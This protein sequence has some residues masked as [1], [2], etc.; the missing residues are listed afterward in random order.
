MGLIR[1]ARRPGYRKTR[2]YK[3]RMHATQPY[4]TV[5]VFV[6]TVSLATYTGRRIQQTSEQESFQSLSDMQ[7]SA[8]RPSFASS[9]NSTTA[10][11]ANDHPIN[12]TGTV[13]HSASWSE[14]SNLAAVPEDGSRVLRRMVFEQS[15]ESGLLIDSVLMRLKFAS[16]GAFFDIECSLPDSGTYIFRL[17]DTKLSV[18]YRFGAGSQKLLQEFAAPSMPSNGEAF[19]GREL[20]IRFGAKGV[21]AHADS[22]TFELLDQQS[23]RGAVLS[24]ATNLTRSE[25]FSFRLAS[26]VDNEKAVDEGLRWIF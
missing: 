12:F 7:T 6:L 19:L 1:T 4:W 22:S 25:I 26:T 3:H 16:L 2:Y 17:T 24:I 23:L 13:S 14:R 11:A 9:L 18:F 21:S 20:E 5:L 8:G 10:Q 15:R